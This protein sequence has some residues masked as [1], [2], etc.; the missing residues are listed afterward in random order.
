M[1]PKD[2]H[3]GLYLLIH[4]LQHLQHL[5]PCQ[6]VLLLTWVPGLDRQHIGVQSCEAHELENARAGE[7]SPHLTHFYLPILA[8][9]ARHVT[10]VHRS[11]DDDAS[12][13]L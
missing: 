2:T 7:M 12:H 13:W 5:L 4:G 9:P 11:H 3:S 8:C 6:I 1:L 10:P